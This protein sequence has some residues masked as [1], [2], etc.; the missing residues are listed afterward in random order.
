MEKTTKNIKTAVKQASQG[1]IKDIEV[2]S[3]SDA[4]AYMDKVNEKLYNLIN[5]SI[6]T[7]ETNNIVFFNSTD[8]I[9]N[10][11]YN[12]VMDYYHN[13][14]ATFSNLVDFRRNLL[15]GTGLQPVIS[16]DTA[17]LEFINR[18]NEYGESLQDIWR[19]MCFDYSLFETYYLECLWSPK[20]D[21]TIASIVHHSPDTIRAVANINPNLP[22]VNM[23]QLSRA[24]GR[25]N[26]LG[27]KAQPAM[28]GISIANFNP[29]S[30]AADSARQLL[31]CKRYTA[32]N[33]VY[34][35]PS[36]NS[37]L[38]YVELDNQ[39]SRY[40][41]S[42]VS[43]GF[44]PQTIVVLNGN[45]DKPTK[46]EFINRFKKRY[47]GVDGDRTLFIW[48]VDEGTKPVIMPFN[49]VD[50]TPMLQALNDMATEKIGVGFGANA[51]IIGV[52]S[53]GT[54]LQSDINKLAV[55][56]NFYYKA[57]VQPLQLEMITTLNK[58]MKQN[59]LS[60][61][62]V[63]TPSLQLEAPQTQATQAQPNTIGG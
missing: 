34:T 4:Y 30:W 7:T 6:I 27:R 38:S 35:I 50:I 60:D 37:I 39:L 45:P 16:G 20:N 63:V 31:A 33:E 10:G 24:W 48:S 21:G 54:S 43:K 59:G 28:Q 12:Q 26:K 51:E 41:L 13:A 15:I 3:E 62:M 57:K 58:I 49:Q 2:L 23:W 11:Y 14:S 5:P 53:K 40:A 56:Y 52:S 1:K 19:K 9:D 61:L 18:E 32:G 29:K 22:Y 25:T 55:S 42:T 46:D 47:T 8:E 17:T 36:F 44:T